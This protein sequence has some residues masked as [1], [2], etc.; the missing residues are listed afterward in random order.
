MKK[1][2]VV[3]IICNFLF[4]VFALQIVSAGVGIKWDQESA[5]VGENN[6]VC[7]NSYS[8]YNPWSSES[9][10]T[11]GLSGEINEVLVMQE[12]ETKL[13]PAFTS[14]NESVPIGFC[15]KVPKLYQRDCSI[16]GKFLCELKCEEAMKIYDGD[17]VIS[18]VPNPTAI[19]GTGGSSTQM[20]VSAPLRIRVSCTPHTRDYT[21][22]YLVLALIA[23]IVIFTILFRKYRK[24]KVERDR[25]KLRKLRAEIS[26]EGGNKSK[27]EKVKKKKK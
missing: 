9:Y 1:V 23:A 10:V 4:V 11:I 20:S 2:E 26:K 14:S 19:S 18:S 8:V 27:R 25:E 13:I 16:A 7:L 6:E 21:L 17:V 24:P 12:A 3:R 5:I 22:L 15:F